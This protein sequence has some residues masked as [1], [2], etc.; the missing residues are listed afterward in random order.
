MIVEANLEYLFSPHLDLL[1]FI[2]VLSLRAE[3]LD[4]YLGQDRAALCF[5]SRKLCLKDIL[6]PKM[7]ESC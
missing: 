3:S 6:P 5:L 1:L 7:L 2:L 4:W